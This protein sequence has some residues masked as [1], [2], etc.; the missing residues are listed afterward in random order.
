MPRATDDERRLLSAVVALAER[1][2][3][4]VRLLIAPGV[5][6]FDSVVETALRLGSSEIHVGE[7][8]TLSAD[9]QA[10]LLGDAWER[11]P[12]ARGADVRLVVH[13]P[14]RR[15]R[16]LSS[17][18]P[19]AR[20]QARRLR[21]HS[22]ALAR[23]GQGHRTARAPPRRGARGIDPYGTTTL[24]PRPRGGAAA[25]ARHRAPCRRARR[26]HPT[27]RLRPP[28]RH[29]AQ[30]A[31]QRPGRGPDRPVARRSG[32][33]VPH[34]AAQGRR[35]DVR[36]SVCRGSARSAQGDGVRG[37]RRAAERHG[38]GRPH[39]VPRGTA[40]RS[41][42][43]PARATDAGGARRRRRPARL[44]GRVD[45]AAHDAAVR[46]GAGRLDDR[47][48]ARLHPRARRGQRDAERHLRRR[49]A[50]RA[51]RRHLD[52][53]AAAGARRRN[54]CAA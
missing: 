20:P 30:P 53:R 15:H 3:R 16:R 8:E 35:R 2:A 18:R 27:T 29:G 9:D 1:E 7:S 42:A 28:A 47:A 50:R 14:A 33:G 21:R 48:G 54:R 6:V 4:P 32:A 23:R 19:R 40:R 36:V 11:A 43:P 31:G 37:R 17:R 24:R 51:D 10:R 5:N 34:P 38:A 12:H 46:R 45:R 22:P 39:D 52:P 49:R 26:G 44:S 25:G 13:H 41:H